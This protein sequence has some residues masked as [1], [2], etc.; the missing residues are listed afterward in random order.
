MTLQALLPDLLILLTMAVF[1]I[2]GIG[3]GFLRTL[4]RLI[5]LIV[6]LIGARVVADHFAPAVA[7]WLVP[8]LEPVIAQKL[9]NS[10]ANAIAEPIASAIGWIFVF[11]LVFVLLRMA[12]WLM[13][14]L[15]DGLDRM[16]VLHFLNHFFGGLIGF[17]Q[18]VIVI[19]IV[20]YILNLL[21]LLPQELIQNSFLIRLFVTA[22]SAR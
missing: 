14:R 5:S 10:A 21:G 12:C 1:V 18:S 2:F 11:L 22:V 9:A 3:R 16:P 6:S 20:I 7:E 4:A 8:K 17:I 13:I 15:L 19:T